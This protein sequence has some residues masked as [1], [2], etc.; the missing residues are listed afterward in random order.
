VGITE[1]NAPQRRDYIRNVKH[2]G[3]AVFSGRAKGK[4]QRRRPRNAEA[5]FDFEVFLKE[6]SRHG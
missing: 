5:R 4:T 1:K 6:M 2:T 3:T